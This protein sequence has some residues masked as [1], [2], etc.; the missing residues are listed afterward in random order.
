MNVPNETRLAEMRKLATF[1]VGIDGSADD[2]L[3]LFGEIDRLR[4]ITVDAVAML[5]KHQWSD[6]AHGCY[7]TA[8]CCPECLGI[9]SEESINN[10]NGTHTQGTGHKPCCA[11]A[12]ALCI[13]NDKE[14]Q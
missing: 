12:K 13:E 11:I 7:N 8:R 10:G 6:T 1:C 5:T 3:E 2:T 4:A 9:H 14:T